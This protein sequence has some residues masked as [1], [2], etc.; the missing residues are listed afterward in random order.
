MVYT[1]HYFKLFIFHLIKPDDDYLGVQA[2]TDTCLLS[3]SSQEESTPEC[4]GTELASSWRVSP[5]EADSETLLL[6]TSFLQRI[7]EKVQF[8]RVKKD[9]FD[10][11]KES[12]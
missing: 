1:M 5:R 6:A 10:I 8:S 7:N 4:P 11:I 2:P 12:Q 3:T 9:S